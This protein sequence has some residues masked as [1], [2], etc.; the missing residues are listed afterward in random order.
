MSAH[1][2]LVVALVVAGRLDAI[3]DDAA[4][5]A[6]KTQAVWQFAACALHVIMQLLTVEVC[7]SLILSAATALDAPAAVKVMTRTKAKPRITAS[8]DLP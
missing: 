5:G 7:A 2:V 8:R 3:K 6:G 1:A 4:A